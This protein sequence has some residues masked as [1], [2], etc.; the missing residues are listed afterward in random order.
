MDEIQWGRAEKKKLTHTLILSYTHVSAELPNFQT[1]H[2]IYLCFASPCR[3]QEKMKETKEKSTHI[4]IGKLKIVHQFI[5]F[6]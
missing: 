2:H 3:T 5:R 6:R 4:K 1:N